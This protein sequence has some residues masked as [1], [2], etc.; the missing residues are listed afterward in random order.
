MDGR[1]GRAGEA[2]DGR[3]GR[4]REATDGN[5][6]NLNRTPPPSDS[7]RRNDTGRTPSPQFVTR[8]TKCV[9]RLDLF[10]KIDV[11]AM[12]HHIQHA[13]LVDSDTMTVDTDS[14]SILMKFGTPL[15]GFHVIL[16]SK[17]GGY[18]FHNRTPTCPEAIATEIVDVVFRAQVQCRARGNCHAPMSP[19][20]RLLYVIKVASYGDIWDIAGVVREVRSLSEYH[21]LCDL[22]AFPAIMVS[23]KESPDNLVGKNG[24]RTRTPGS[25]TFCSI[26]PSGKV[27]IK[28]CGKDADDVSSFY[29]AI[30]HIVWK[31]ARTRN[32]Y[33]D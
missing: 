8:S 1:A 31:H 7:N 11:R 32:R 10:T 29:D 30:H 5:I 25:R 6:L 20:I 9:Y 28:A 15:P 21:S 14:D 17:G 19:R 13:R 18:V 24:S 26:F 3:S 23:R 2:K 22:D 16:G 12:V 27:V 4:I 33:S